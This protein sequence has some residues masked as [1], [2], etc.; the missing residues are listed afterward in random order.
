MII[1]QKLRKRVGE[2]GNT[3]TLTKVGPNVQELSMTNLLR[4]QESHE[5]QPANVQPS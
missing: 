3:L 4:E 2:E 5:D 1:L